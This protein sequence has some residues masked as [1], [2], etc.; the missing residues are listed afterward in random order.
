MG[1]KHTHGT[2]LKRGDTYVAHLTNIDPPEITRDDK[3]VTDHDSP[4]STREFI[5]GLL[6]GGEVPLEGYL[7]PTDDTQRSLAAAAQIEEPEPWTIEFPTV[8]VLSV[9]FMGYVN[10]FKVGAAPVDG[11]LTFTSKIKVT[12]LPT[13]TV[14]ESAGLS[15]LALEGSTSGALDLMPAFADP[16]EYYAVAANA[17]ETVTVTPTAA[18][19]VIAINGTTVISGKPSGAIAL[20]AGEMT[21]VSVKAT[22]EGKAPALYTL[23]I[24]REAV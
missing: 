10:S 11:E 24:Y 5:P 9:N 21:T 12:G 7:Y 17:D 4:N 22:E 18:A 1:A 2:K 8:P 14:D 23:K 3:D 19:H 16:G 20:A 6:N 13:I 15:I